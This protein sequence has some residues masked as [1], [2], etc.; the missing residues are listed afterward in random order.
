MFRTRS[1]ISTTERRSVR[2]RSQSKERP[3]TWRVIE[4]RM[5][6]QGAEERVWVE[7]WRESLRQTLCVPRR[8][9]RM[10]R[11]KNYLNVDRH[12]RKHFRL[13][14]QGERR[15]LALIVRIATQSLK[16]EAEVATKASR[17]PLVGVEWIRTLTAITNHQPKLANRAHLT[18]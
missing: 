2:Y 9:H 18:T 12:I 4:L 6:L 13:Q 15:T 11:E 17:S 3:E 14:V 10:W 8:N 5:K 1:M 16:W 7:P